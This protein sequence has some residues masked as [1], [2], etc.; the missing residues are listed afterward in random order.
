MLS[1]H[2]RYKLGTILEKGGVNIFG[3]LVF[4]FLIALLIIAFLRWVMI[5]MMGEATPEQSGEIF[6]QF[7]HIFLSMTDP[8]NIGL[9]VSCGYVIY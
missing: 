5:L 9:D 7:F 4:I 6:P 2:F 3:S 8:G 1:K